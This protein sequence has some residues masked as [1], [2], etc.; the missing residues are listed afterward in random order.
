MQLLTATGE[1]TIVES[2]YDDIWEQVY[3]YLTLTASL[4]QSGNL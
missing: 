1:K 3:H 4:N 2:S